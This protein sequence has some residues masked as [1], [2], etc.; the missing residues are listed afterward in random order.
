MEILQPS[1]T[2]LI[3]GIEEYKR[4][5]YPLF[6]VFKELELVECYQNEELGIECSVKVYY[7]NQSEQYFL[8]TGRP[9]SF[10]VTREFIDFQINHIISFIKNKNGEKH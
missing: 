4:W 2:I 10:G 9:D 7:N 5:D 6:E 8:I 3:T 1:I